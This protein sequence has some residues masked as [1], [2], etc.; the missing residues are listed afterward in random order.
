MHRL[1]TTPSTATNR[2]SPSTRC[3]PRPRLRCP[4]TCC[5]TARHCPSLCSTSRPSSPP[6][7]HSLPLGSWTSPLTSPSPCCP[8]LLDWHLAFRRKRTT[9]TLSFE[10]AAA[11]NPWTLKGM[12]YASCSK[13]SVKECELV[14]GLMSLTFSGCNR[15]I[16]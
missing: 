13:P 4:L 9:T 16:R 15:S 7:S 11:H 3:D 5:P 2:G 10:A 8:Y 6:P 1:P 14:C 12:M